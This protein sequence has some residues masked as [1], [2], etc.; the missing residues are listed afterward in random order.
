M[1]DAH[2]WQKVGETMTT[3]LTLEDWLGPT[4]ALIECAYCEQTA[5][6][7]LLG[8]QGPQLKDRIY[9]VR[10]LPIDATQVYRHNISREYCD[11]TRKNAETDTLINLA[12][13]QTTLIQTNV[14]DLVVQQS[15]SVTMTP[16]IQHWQNIAPDDYALWF[17]RFQAN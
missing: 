3:E 11:L 5:V 2:S 9:G 15:S 4:L 14:S 7:F 16:V 8:W 13:E 12:S 6:L 10:N 17:L 1:D